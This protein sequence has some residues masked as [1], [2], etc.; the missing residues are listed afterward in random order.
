MAPPDAREALIE[1]ARRAFAD[2][3]DE[4]LII[5]AAVAFAGAFLALLLV[6]RR[7]FVSAV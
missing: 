1:A 5:A 6:R 2:G 7:D 3:L 4:I